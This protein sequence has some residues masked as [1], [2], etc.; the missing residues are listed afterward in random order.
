MIRIGGAV[1]CYEASELLMINVAVDL[2]TSS[3]FGEW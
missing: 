2:L 3:E 1:F